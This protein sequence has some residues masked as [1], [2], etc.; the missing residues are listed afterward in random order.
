MGLMIA[1]NPR[2]HKM[3]ATLLPMIFPSAIVAKPLRAAD[4]DTNSSGRDVPTDITISAIK[5]SD[6]PK[7]TA[8]P[9]IEFTRIQAPISIPVNPINI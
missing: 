4:T 7:A 6:I 9:N 8:S 5:Y 1:A 2:T 3:L